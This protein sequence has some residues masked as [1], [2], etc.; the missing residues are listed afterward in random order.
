MLYWCE[1]DKPSGRNYTVGVTSSD[2]FVIRAFLGWLEKYYDIPKARIKLRLHLWPN[3]N[4]GEAQKYWAKKLDLPMSSFTKSYI[5]ERSGK[6]NKYKNG[7][8]RA[9]IHSTEILSDILKRIERE[10]C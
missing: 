5:K 1:G 6:N 8:C 7:I 3:S 4:E 2:F 9:S 10:F